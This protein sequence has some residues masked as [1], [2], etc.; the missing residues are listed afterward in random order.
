MIISLISGKALS[1]RSVAPISITCLTARSDCRTGLI[2]F[3]SIVIQSSV[4][5]AG[6]E[7]TYATQYGCLM[8][9]PDGIECPYYY[10]NFHRR[11]AAVDQCNLLVAGPFE[12][13]WQSSLCK[14]CPVP[15]IKRANSCETMQLSLRIIKRGMKFWEKDRISVQ[16]TCKFSH[17]I[18]VKSDDRLRSLPYTSHFRGWTRKREIINF[19]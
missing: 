2:F 10:A 5:S 12:N 4:I 14:T 3:T 16:A 17:T 8:L 15:D 11:T 6:T 13:D 19:K 7:R 1:F 18:V 9:T